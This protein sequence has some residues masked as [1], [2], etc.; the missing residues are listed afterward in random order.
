M[1]QALAKIVEEYGSEEQSDFRT[2]V[3]KGLAG[4]DKSLSPKYFYDEQGSKYFD[5][6][7]ELQ[8]YYPYKTE[9]KLLPEV[10]VSLNQRLTKPTSIIEFGAGSLLK[11]RPLLEKI[12]AIEE[13]V[14]IDISGEHLKAACSTLASDFKNI[15]MKPQEADFC[16]AL[17]LDHYD[18]TRLGFFPGS[19]IGNFTPNEAK[20]F[21]ENARM[22]LGE[23]AFMLIGVDT[24]KISE[25][26][27]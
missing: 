9:L 16:Q 20:E 27:S 17:Q 24:K 1:Q 19:T 25:Q 15:A 6:I 5:E 18:G 21:L 3:L 11:I 4:E 7:C 10:A 26:A 12:E 23:N 14:P 2:D 8:E 13:F 22:T